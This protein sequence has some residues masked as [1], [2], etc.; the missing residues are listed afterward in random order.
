MDYL[1]KLTNKEIKLYDIPKHL[2]TE[3]LCEITC[4]QNDR[5]LID[6][7]KNLRTEKFFNRVLLKN[8]S[9]IQYLDFIK[10]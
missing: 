1:E 8:P 9:I 7:P 2:R 6:V 4:K 3:K 10:E 5:A